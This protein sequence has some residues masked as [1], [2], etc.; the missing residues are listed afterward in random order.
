MIN[1]SFRAIRCIDDDRRPKDW[2]HTHTRMPKQL[3]CANIHI[4]MANKRY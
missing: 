2:L 3:L 4:L 1:I